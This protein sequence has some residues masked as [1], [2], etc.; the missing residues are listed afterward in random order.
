[1]KNWKTTLVGAIL[2]LFVAV[3]P[4]METGAVDWKKIVIACGVALFGYLAKDFNVSGT[5]N[6]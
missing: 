4:I 1:M 2:A 3:Q 5:T 6:L